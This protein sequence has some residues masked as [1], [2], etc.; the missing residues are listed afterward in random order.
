MLKLYKQPIVI[1]LILIITLSYLTDH[2]LKFND[3]IRKSFSNELTNEQ[4]LK[5]INIKEKLAWVNYL[6]II[7]TTIVKISLITLL[8]ELGVFFYDK[9]PEI[10]YKKLFNIVVK[11]EFIFLLVIVTKTLWFYFFKTDY[12]L[13]DLQY[14]YPFSALNIVGY[15]NVSPWFVY[16]LQV[17]NAFELIYWFLLAYMLSK[18]LKTDFDTGLI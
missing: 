6:I 11:A 7:F 12:T 10:K 3:V 9:L 14:F 13:E 16:S 8:L 2:T 1:L 4:I 15:Q 5:F 18:E 17:L